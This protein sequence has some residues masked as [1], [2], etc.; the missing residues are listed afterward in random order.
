[1]WVSCSRCLGN[2]LSLAL[3]R[4]PAI[5]L[6]PKS[7]ALLG[8]GK[9]LLEPC[10]RF[11]GETPSLHGALD[12]SR[13][14]LP[15]YAPGDTST[16]RAGH[17]YSLPVYRLGGRGRRR[18]PLRALERAH[19]CAGSDQRRVGRSAQSF[20]EPR[21]SNSTPCSTDE[22]RQSW[23]SSSSHLPKYGLLSA[24][25]WPARQR[26]AGSLRLRRRRRESQGRKQT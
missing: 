6:A 9:S 5:V 26:F 12:A 23:G 19:A 2:L 1:M 11:S 21:R 20:T 22:A 24:S 3:H 17:L 4:R 16:S 7:T 18:R 25:S 14:T 15:R 13:A 8:A 10:F